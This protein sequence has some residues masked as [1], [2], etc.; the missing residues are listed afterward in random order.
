MCCIETHETRHAGSEA[1]A[2]TLRRSAEKR[3]PTLKTP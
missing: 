3:L 2:V 1:A